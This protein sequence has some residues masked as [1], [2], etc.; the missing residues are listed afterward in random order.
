METR[1][2]G[3]LLTGKI[4]A[5]LIEEVASELICGASLSFRHYKWR[6]R[7]GALG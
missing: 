1:E 6:E 5:D 2:G 7:P 3:T 4:R